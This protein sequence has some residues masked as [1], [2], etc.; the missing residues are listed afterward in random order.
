M[1][2]LSQ[3]VFWIVVVFVVYIRSKGL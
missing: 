3:T 1:N 2:D